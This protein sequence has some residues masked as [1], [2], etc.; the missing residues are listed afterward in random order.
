MVLCIVIGCSKRSGRDKDVSFF[1]IPTIISH[2]I[3]KDR[4]LS[5]E[6]RAGLFSVISRADLTDKILQNDRICSR[7]FISG[8]PAS[9]M[10]TQA[11]TG[12]LSSFQGEVEE[13]G[14]CRGETR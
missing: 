5:T 1:S 3:K 7:H 12:C 10:T 8:N 14:H 6:R 4:K 13:C 9:F 11:L 2:R